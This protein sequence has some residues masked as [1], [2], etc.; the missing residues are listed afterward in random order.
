[1]INT[2]TNFKS[3]M[4]SKI[5][6]ISIIVLALSSCGDDRGGVI[7][8]S[9]GNQGGGTQPGGGGFAFVLLFVVVAGCLLAMFA[10]DRIKKN[11]DNKDSDDKK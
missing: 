6:G 11:S 10:M 8:D 1:M 5:V 9:T 7:V 4:I 3:S 2:L